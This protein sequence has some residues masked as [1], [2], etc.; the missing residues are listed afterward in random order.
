[1]FNSYFDI[2][3]GYVISWLIIFYPPNVHQR[4][5]DRL[6]TDGTN[7]EIQTGWISQMDC[8]LA[9]PE[10]SHEQ[11]QKL[12]DLLLIVGFYL[13]KRNHYNPMLEQ[14]GIAIET[15]KNSGTPQFATRFFSLLTSETVKLHGNVFQVQGWSSRPITTSLRPPWNNGQ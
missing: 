2:T 7:S 8:W 5:W 14:H 12:I 9:K 15:T 13:L 1:M 6:N 3:R 4:Q 11:R 10:T